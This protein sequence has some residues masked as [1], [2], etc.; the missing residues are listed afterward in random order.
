MGLFEKLF[1]KQEKIVPQGYFKTLTG[2]TP[3]FSSFGGEIYESELV[4]SCV[5]ARARHISKLAINVV[6]SAKPSLKTKL[7]ANPNEWQTWSQFLYRLSTI[8]DIQNTA[9]IV[10]VY[11]KFGDITGIYPILPNNS[12][13]VQYQ[14]EPWIRYHFQNGQTAAIEM[15]N[16]GIL[17]KYQYKNDF[18]G[19]K[20]NALKP[21]MELVN[22]QNQGINEGVKSSATFRFMAQ[23][24]NFS[25]PN[26]LRREQD[27][28]TREN[29]SGEGGV[30]LFPNTYTNIKQIDSKPFIVDADQMKIIQTNVYNY[31]GVNE[32]IVQ[33]TANGDELDAFFNGV[34]EPFSIQLSEVLTN[35]FFTLNEQNRENKVIVSA[36]R[37]QYM[38]VASKV[39]LATQLGD[40]GLVTINEI[41]ELFNYAPLEGEEGNKRPARGEYYFA[42]DEGNV[43]KKEDE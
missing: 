20:N 32:R 13:V 30:L 18:F 8:L 25:Q 24:N 5:D 34:I 16:V 9:F 29:L 4:R 39:S 27:R 28:F 2:Y 33:S 19:E 14:G 36:N 15:R 11:D 43:T 22:I 21:T 10:P 7:R 17:T 23:L 42:D 26:D 35:M 38:S 6:G 3:V 1:P 12:E 40:R 41:R 37:L 31:F